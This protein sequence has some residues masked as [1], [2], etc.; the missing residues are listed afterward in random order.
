[1]IHQIFTPVLKEAVGRAEE[2]L[3]N[4]TSN[5]LRMDA[6]L[7]NFRAMAAQMNP[8]PHDWQWNGKWDSQQMY[9]V[10]EARARAMAERHGGVAKRMEAGK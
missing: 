9:G 10:T 1:M 7:N 2:S 3:V 8:E 6:V 4:H 5:E